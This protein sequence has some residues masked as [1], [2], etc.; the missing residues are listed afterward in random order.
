M[1]TPLTPI[2]LIPLADSNDDDDTLRPYAVGVV[3]YD[4]TIP[5]SLGCMT[6]EIRNDT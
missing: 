6:S 2:T 4:V 5:T 3:T 1:A